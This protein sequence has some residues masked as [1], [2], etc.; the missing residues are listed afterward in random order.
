VLYVKYKGQAYFDQQNCKDLFFIPGSTL[1]KLFQDVPSA[2]LE[3]LFPNTK[4]RMNTIDGVMVG[5]PVILDQK[6][7]TPLQRS[8]AP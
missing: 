3:M 4:V 5:V 6:A 7:L 2:D 1:I 8:L